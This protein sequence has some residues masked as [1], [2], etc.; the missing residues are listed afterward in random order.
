M[1]EMATC[2]MTRVASVGPPRGGGQ[3]GFDMVV[4]RAW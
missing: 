3:G 2:I 1:F 4:F